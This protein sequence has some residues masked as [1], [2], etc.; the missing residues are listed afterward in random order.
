LLIVRFYCKDLNHTTQSK[1]G[2][3]RADTL[4]RTQS[5]SKVD[6]N[7]RNYSPKGNLEVRGTDRKRFSRFHRSYSWETLGW[8][9]VK[10]EVKED[11][12]R[13]WLNDQ[14]VNEAIAMKAWDDSAGEWK[15]L[16]K[17][18]I[19]LQAEGAEVFYRNIYIKKI[20]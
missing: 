1:Y 16:T 6:A 12:A 8:N 18:K 17:G 19:M 20:K 11:T 9:K 5:A 15:E 14:L 2:V 3:A 7:V 4:L 13:F 10:I